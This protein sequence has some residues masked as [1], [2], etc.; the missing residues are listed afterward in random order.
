M[1]TKRPLVAIADLP[2]IKFSHMLVE[3]NGDVAPTDF[4]SARGF[5]ALLE[6]LITEAGS[7][8]YRLTT[9]QK[10]PCATFLAEKHSFP[11]DGT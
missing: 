8:S 3:G 6:V 2:K 5:E 4:K 11:T 9:L 7:A 1:P 10:N